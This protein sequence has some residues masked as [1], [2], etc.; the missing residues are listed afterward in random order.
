MDRYSLPFGLVGRNHRDL[1]KRSRYSDHYLMDR[2]SEILQFEEVLE[3]VGKGRARYGVEQWVICPTSEY[4]NLAL[5]PMREALAERG[6]SVATCHEGL[7]ARVSDKSEFRAYSA[8]LGV[9]PPEILCMDARDL[10]SMP[11]VAKPKVNLSRQGRILYPF[12]VRNER[13]LARFRTEAVA[14]D[15]YVERFVHGESWYLLFYIDRHGRVAHGA[16]CN[17]LQQGRGKSILVARARTY[18]EPDVPLRYANRLCSDGYRGFIMVE[19]R[20]MQDRSAVAIEANPRCW[21]PFQLTL[22]AGMGLA[23]AFFRDHG[24][25][26][27]MLAAPFRH[28]YYCWTG[29]IVQAVRSGKGLDAHVGLGTALGHT[30]RSLGSDIYA[31]A[32]SW[33][34]FRYDLMAG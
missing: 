15:Y 32:D 10:P 13:E 12:L 2:T 11:F 6:V 24:H 14:D 3:A 23:E 18:P 8:S 4:L 25:D 22:D 20:R 9:S 1:L 30:L 7:Y 29:G 16:Q 17:V 5:F 28:G 21:G 33:S 34:C 19:V 27:P 31:R 26:I